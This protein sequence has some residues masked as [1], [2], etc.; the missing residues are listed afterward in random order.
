MQLSERCAQRSNVMMNVFIC[1]TQM[2]YATMQLSERCAQRSYVM[3]NLFICQTQMRHATIQ[4]DMQQ[5]S[6]NSDPIT[7]VSK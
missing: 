6:C 5:Y 4:L 3:T 2:L 1:Q 7:L